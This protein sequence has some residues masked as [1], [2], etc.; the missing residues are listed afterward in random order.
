MADRTLTI[1]HADGGSETYTIKRDKF[2]G[3]RSMSVDGNT[4]T[5]DHTAVPKE[6]SK[7]TT[8]GGSKSIAVKREIEPL[9]SKVVGGASAAYSLR[10]LNDKAGNNKVVRVR[11]ASDNCERDFRAKEVKDIATWVNT[12]TVPPLDLQELDADG[13]RTGDLV[14][15]AAAYSLRNLSASYTGNVVDVRRSSDDAEESF[16]A[17]EVADGTLT[18][19]VVPAEVR[20]LYGDAMYFD[21]VNDIVTDTGTPIA[22]VGA[23]SVKFV[24]SGTEGVI[25]FSHQNGTSLHGLSVTEGRTA[26]NVHVSFHEGSD[27]FSNISQSG[28]TAGDIITAVIYYNFTT[29]TFSVDIN[30]GTGDGNLAGRLSTSSSSFNRFQVGANGNSTF[31]AN[32]PIW[33]VIEYDTDQSTEI[34]NWVGNGNTSTEWVDTVGSNNGTVN[35]SPALFTG[36]GYDGFV[37]N[38]YDQSGNDNHATQGTPAS[39]PKIVDGGSL[40]SSG[41]D[42]DGS[43]DFFTF[44]TSISFSGTPASIFALQE[45]QGSSSDA[46]L[47]A[48]SAGNSLTFK[49]N[50]IEYDLSSD[51]IDINPSGLDTGD[52]RLLTV[53]HDGT[54]GNPNVRAYLD[55]SEVIDATPDSD[56]GSLNTA[57]VSYIGKK[58]DNLSGAFLN[59]GLKELIIYVTDQ[60]D[61]RTAIEANIGDHYD[62][63]LPSGVDTGY[64]QVDGFVETW[65][66]QSGNGNDAVQQVSGSQPKI[67]DAGVLVSGGLEFDGVD[68]TLALSGSGLDIFK[69]VGYGQVFTVVTPNRTTTGSNRYFEATTATTGARILL[70]DSQDYASSSRI[71]GRRLD[72]DSFQ[73]VESST[74]HGNNETLVTAF[75]NWADSDAYLYFDGTQVASS[76]SFQTDGNTSDTSSSSA[77]IAGRTGTSLGNFKMKELIIYN[78]DQSANR[79]A[80]ETNINNQYDIY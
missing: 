60:S 19:W 10:D 13:H 31:F 23:I 77:G 80:I 26:G 48:S 2:A 58:R 64:D 44:D 67:V 36:Q 28:F 16:T 24:F 69:D 37:K 1:N 33:D 21:G 39:Q 4:V 68:D 41:L 22:A 3:V 14:E 76:T 40:V 34:R 46:T 29:S 63:D 56:Q 50:E 30:G 12:Q 54:S 45:A 72:S 57:S 53:I 11:R 55:G 61:N 65:Y 18:D 70:G 8:F 66:D 5:V 51:T 75:L 79:V 47:G 20:A 71:G 49:R 32:T 27:A 73:D 15:A 35:G 42:F 74:S 52:E 62:I 38:W 7:E 25:F 43:D 17:A 6:Q 59:G 9:L 78:T